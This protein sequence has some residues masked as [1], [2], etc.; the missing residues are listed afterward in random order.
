MAEFE[1]INVSLEEAGS[2]EALRPILEV[3]ASFHHHLSPRQVL[4]VR[5]GLLGLRL[6][7]FKLPIRQKKMLVLVETDGCFVSGVQA[8]TRCSVNRRT[9]R[10]V[11]IGR[12]AATFINVRTEEAFRVAPR[13]D[14]REQALNHA[15]V[16]NGNR[17]ERYIAMLQAYQQMR[18]EALLKYET[19]T[20]NRP[21]REIISR[22]FLRV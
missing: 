20:L 11:D 4:G 3:S 10:V 9:M 8:A 17:R 6:L 19:V 16:V 18:E 22:P 2:I 7:N 14:V 1:H 5:I 15:C 13:S 12:I 21:V